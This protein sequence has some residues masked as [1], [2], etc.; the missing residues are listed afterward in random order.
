MMMEN[1]MRNIRIEKVTVNMGVGQTGDELKKASAILQTVTGA[2][3]VLTKCKV[4]QPAWGLRLGLTIGAKVTLRGEKAE[5]F[6]REAFTAKGNKLKGKSFDRRGNFGFG[7]KEHID[8]PKI[9]YDPVLGI[10]GMDVLVTLE[11]PGYRVK[12]RKLEKVSPAKSHIIRS[13]EAI[14]FVKQRFGVEVI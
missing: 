1:P 11:R 7:I 3:P 9:K 8:L 5:K 13:D 6:L 12:K 14:D 10:R 2:K 4:K